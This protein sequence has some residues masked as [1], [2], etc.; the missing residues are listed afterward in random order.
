MFE[1]SARLRHKY[2]NCESSYPCFG[3]TWKTALASLLKRVGGRKHFEILW[4]YDY[5]N[6][7]KIMKP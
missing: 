3:K 5:Q 6:D 2:S 4:V 1:Y 7:N